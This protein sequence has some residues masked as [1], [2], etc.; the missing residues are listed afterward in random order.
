VRN[1]NGVCSEKHLEVVIARL[2]NNPGQSLQ[3]NLI[4]GKPMGYLTFVNSGLLK[5]FKLIVSSS[6][7]TQDCQETSESFNKDRSD[8]HTRSELSHE[9]TI[10]SSARFTSEN[11]GL[12]RLGIGPRWA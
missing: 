12:T 1:A 5:E 9:Q 3:A 7:R 11:P 4:S 10:E 6:W 8:A 2:G